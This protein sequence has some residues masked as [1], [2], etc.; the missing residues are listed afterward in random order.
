MPVA[1]RR[2]G[3]TWPASAPTPTKTGSGETSA[4]DRNTDEPA[5]ARPRRMPTSSAS[6]T[7]AAPIAIAGERRPE[8]RGAAH[9]AGEDELVAAGVLLG[10]QCADRGQHSPQTPAKIA[11]APSAPR[12]VP[13]DCQQVVRHAVEQPHGAVVA[14]AARELQAVLERRVGVAVGRALD[15]A[16]SR[17]SSANE[18]V[19]AR[20]SRAVWRASALAAATTVAVVVVQ[21]DLLQR[22][23]AAREREHG[24]ARERGDERPDPAGDRR[25]HRV[26]ARARERARRAARAASGPA[27][28]R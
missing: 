21:E 23:L 13:A 24:M 7:T 27:R 17:N 18:I 1:T 20:A 5:P 25:A 12:H 8:D 28:R 26:V 2:V 22:R 10:A 14:E 15:A 19:R 3:A 9:G 6:H 16:P 4:S 11:K